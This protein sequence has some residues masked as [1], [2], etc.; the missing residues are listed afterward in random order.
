MIIQEIPFTLKD[1]RAAV[2]R[3]PR[4][5]DIPGMLDY[6]RVRAGETE[7]LIRYPE[8]CYKYTAEG[9]KALFDRVN[10]SDCEAMPVCEVDGK[11]VGCCNISWSRWKKTKHRA[12]VGIAILRDYWD[13]GIGTKMFSELIRLAKSNADILQIELDFIE[14]NTRARA[15]YEKFGFRIT[16]VKPDAVR[17][18]DGTFKNEY[19][20][21]KKIER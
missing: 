7:F 12:F 11:I 20:M 9:E 10:A 2:L 19:S 18:K 6:L 1:G 4:D 13:Q 17:L 8:E 15:L 14:G 21:I 3:S 16:G 5:E